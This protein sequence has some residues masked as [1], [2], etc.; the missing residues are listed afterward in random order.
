MRLGASVCAGTREIATQDLFQVR[1]CAP[2]A[3]RAVRIARRA[4][5][6]A[7]MVLAK[8]A[9]RAAEAAR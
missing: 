9:L 4:K 8:A 6:K 7:R 5:A 1:A 3:E 2:C